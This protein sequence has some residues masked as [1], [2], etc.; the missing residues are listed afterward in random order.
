MRSLRECERRRMD[1]SFT[2]CH[3]ER[4]LNNTSYEKTASPLNVVSVRR[5]LRKLYPV[6]QNPFVDKPCGPEGDAR[7][8]MILCSFL[9]FSLPSSRRRE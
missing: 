7:A 9:K 1:T 6:Y 5:Q 2:V 3:E 8:L 4:A